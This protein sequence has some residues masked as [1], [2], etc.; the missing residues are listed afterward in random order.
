MRK[1]KKVKKL[2]R[3]KSQREALIKELASQ[4][5]NKEKIKTTT[6]K[7]KELRRKAEKFITK[8]KKGNLAQR[9]LLL[10]YFSKEL[11]KKLI[12]DIAPRYKERKGG[13]TRIVKIGPRKSDGAE[14]SIIELLK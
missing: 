3:P 6:K 1:R 5:F 13:Y 4:L 11:V 8:A 9:R 7:A 10:C 12:E 14:M 2:H